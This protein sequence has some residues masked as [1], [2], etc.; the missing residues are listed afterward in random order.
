[1][2]TIIGISGSLRTKSY[3]TALLRAAAGM[4]PE[5]VE[6]IV[7]SIADIPLYSQDVEDELGIPKAVAEMKEVIAEADGILIATPEYN[8]SMPGVLKNAVDWL[9]RPPSD[10]R[11][12]FGGKPVGI[13]GASPGRF[14]AI[15]G[16]DSWLPVLHI[17]GTQ[18]WGGERLRVANAAAIFDENGAIA[19]KNVEEQL[20]KYVSEFVQFAQSAI[21]RSGLG[22]AR[23]YTG[24]D[25]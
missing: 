1:M 20:R 17:L 6:L 10:V 21:A 25:S 2:V 16:Q 15:L 4:M 5:G 13:I 19:D 7:Y 3:N 11:R 12:V 9:S 18:V 23:S 22:A 14:G 8:N 24:V